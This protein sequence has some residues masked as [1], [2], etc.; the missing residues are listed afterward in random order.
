VCQEVGVESLIAIDPEAALIGF[1]CLSGLIRSVRLWMSDSALKSL[2]DDRIDF[3]PLTT[4]SRMS[5]IVSHRGSNV[6]HD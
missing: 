3:A 6:F 2:F 4:E 5:T 1:H